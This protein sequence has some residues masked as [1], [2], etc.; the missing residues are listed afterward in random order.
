MVKIKVD[1]DRCN[2]CM[3]CVYHCPT[4]VFRF[5]ENEIIVHED[6]CIECYGCVPLCPTRAIKILI[7]NSE[8]IR[9]KHL[10]S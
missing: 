3:L 8:D 4:G 1:T 7:N 10:E 5:E 6:N 2:K 9:Q